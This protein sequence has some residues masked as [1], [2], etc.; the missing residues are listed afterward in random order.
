M[1]VRILSFSKSHLVLV[2]TNPLLLTFSQPSSSPHRQQNN[3]LT[4]K[5]NYDITLKTEIFDLR[6]NSMLLTSFLV[7][8]LLFHFLLPHTKFQ[9]NKIVFN[10]WN[11]L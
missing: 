1:H 9:L 10:S 5:C 6:I 11:K 4:T 3:I 8:K 2:N 7:F